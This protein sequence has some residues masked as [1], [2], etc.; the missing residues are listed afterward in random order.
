MKRIILFIMIFSSLSIWADLEFGKDLFN[1][2]LY[3]EAISEFEK[4]VAFSP[5]S[6]QAQE[7]IFYIGKSYFAREQYS[8]AEN[9]YK[10][11]TEGFPNNSFRDEVMF[12]LI[13]VQ[14]LQKKYDD[15]ILNSEEMLVKYPLSDFTE[16][17][18]SLYLT[19]LY[20]LREYGRGIE[21]GKRF[22]KEYDKSQF[23]PD[24]LL[25]LAKIYFSSNLADE[26]QKLLNRLFSEFPNQNAAW[27]AVELEAELIEKSQGK[28]AAAKLL[29]AKMKQEI[30]RFFEESL[31]L[32]LAKYYID[33]QWDQSAFLELEKLITKFNNSAQLDNYVILF[34]Q[35]RLKLN[36]FQQIVDD[37]KNFSKV[38]RESSRKAEYLLQIA[39]AYL[40]L[41]MM[42]KAEEFIE[43]SREIKPTEE[44]LYNCDMLTAK[45]SIKQGKLVNAI[46]IYQELVNFW[47]ADKNLILMQLGDIYFEKLGDYTKAETYYARIINSYAPTKI[48]N[49]A[50]FKAAFCLENLSQ[51]EE[52]LD[53]LQQINMELVNDSDFKVRV[54]NKISYIRKFKQQNYKVAFDRL[55]QSVFEFSEN[56]DKSIL[57]SEII[58]ILSEDLKKYEEALLLL[59]EDDSYEVIYTKAKLLLKLTEKYQAESKN[60][61]VQR[62][63]LSLQDLMMHLDREQHRS[64]VTELDLKKK[65]LEERQVTASLAAD[66]DD[67][68]REFPNGESVNEFW[69]ELYRY[70]KQLD[71]HSRAATFAA[72]LQKDDTFSADVFFAAKVTLAEDYFKRDMHDQALRNYRIADEYIDMKR[73]MIF[74]HYAVTLNETG[75][76]DEARDKLA[77]LINNTGYFN[78]YETVINYFCSILRLIGEYA[79]AIKYLKMLPEE[80]QNDAYWKQL[81]EDYLILGDVEN[82]KYALMRIVKKDYETL[83]RLGHLQYDSKEYEMAKYTFSELID[84]NKNDLENYK[85]LGQIAF[86]QEDYLEAAKKYKVIVDKLGDDFSNYKGIRRIALENIIS[87]YRIENRPKAERLT[88]TF[89]KLLSEEDINE[90]ELNRGIYHID[91][92]QKKAIKIFS[93]LIKGKKVIASTRIKAYFWRGLVR[94]EQ[95]SIEEAEADFSTVANSID[96]EMSNKA[97]LKLGTIKFSQEK[98][99]E[100][101]DHY[102]L[103]I[104]NDDQGLLAFD[105]ARNF[106]FVC[107]TIEKW[108]KAIA[109]YQI[110]LERWG[111]QKLEGET[112]FDIAYCYYRDREY[113]NAAAMFAR[114]TTLIQD[115]ELKAEA[116]YWIGESY[117]SLEE[118]EQSV[119]EFL[120]VGYNYPEFTHWAASAELKAGEAYLEMNK[121]TKA[122]QIYERIIDK[123]GKYSQWGKEAEKRLG[124]L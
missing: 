79:D 41:N 102:F 12:N 39:E 122:R 29:A 71:D 19:S 80:N 28:T 21:K 85:I 83:S 5:T 30:P 18:L 16:Q 74:F 27:K 90:I 9:S 120:K 78:G 103:V 37:Y 66:L 81:A 60:H 70:Y 38:F 73:P 64:W 36:Y 57:R 101:L 15:V 76:T 13:E 116:Q 52:A 119:S 63:L 89:K 100:A 94:L 77:F 72:L 121:R 14:L 95:K 91:L 97:N 82:G 49:E 24:V 4:V 112:L 56:A 62:N 87:L 55:I 50:L 42:E 46:T 108:Q 1:D 33:L 45:L 124:N 84:R 31:R 107:K 53:M 32:K 92:D 51:N 98:Y 54:Q 20:D 75:N 96:K 8:L 117:F 88:K 99:E 48:L 23:L 35:T 86:L 7:A 104:Q 22:I 106:A 118:F 68:I 44:N 10:K 6:E 3:E 109:A 26:G 17:T 25:I 58:N 2:Q 114:S 69:Y 113:K 65:L 47:Y 34:T 111:D 40:N 11:I 115:E 105:A 43:N 123:Y 61:L 67:Y 59:E 93:S 110:I